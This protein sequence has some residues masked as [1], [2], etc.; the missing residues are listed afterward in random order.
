[1]SRVPLAPAEEGR[2]DREV[3][4]SLLISAPDPEAVLQRLARLRAIGPYAL[5]ARGL[6]RIVD[7]YFDT[8]RGELRRQGLAL[9]LREV[10]GT[11]LIGLKGP[12]RARSTR[13][14][15]RYELERPFSAEAVAEVGRRAGLE[16]RPVAEADGADPE[17]LLETSLGVRRIQRRE[18][19]RLVREVADTAGG[20]GPVLAELV[21]DRVRFEVEGRA[22]R[23]YEVEIESKAPGKGTEAARR[24]AAELR[25]RYPDELAEWPWGKLATGSAVEALLREGALEEL[26]PDG[27]L[28]GAGYEQIRRRLERR[29]R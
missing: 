24:I 8:P 2:S 18:T 12:R 20:P 9:R 22:V 1:M 29:R 21:L 26:G 7:R 16:V 25:S 27:T 13:T 5:A 14:E 6:E 15:D 17:R 3:E 28:T 10:G 23:H 19:D 4:L 11:T